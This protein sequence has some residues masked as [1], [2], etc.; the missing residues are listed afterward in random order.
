MFK[1][2]DVHDLERYEQLRQLSIQI[3]E[4]YSG[5]SR[6]KIALTFAS[7]TGYATPKVDIRAVILNEEKEILLVQ[8]KSD[9]RWALPG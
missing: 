7:D 9:G 8:E 5:V 4:T 2:K 1:G 6:D 3:M